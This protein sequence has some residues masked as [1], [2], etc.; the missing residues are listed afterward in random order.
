MTEPEATAPMHDGR[1]AR[2]LHRLSW[3]RVALTLR[4]RFSL[5][6]LVSV[7][8][9]VAAGTVA[10]S[11]EVSARLER[12]LQAQAM[13]VTGAIRTDLEQTA[14]ALDEELAV[15]ADPRAGVARLLTA[16]RVETRFLGAQARL[17][18]GRLEV[19][20]VL[21]KDGSILTSG[22]WPASFGALDPL[23]AAYASEPGRLPRIVDEA[24]PEGSSPALER[25]TT[26]RA[27]GRDLVVVAG[28]FLDGP[29]LE[30]LRARTG[31]DLLAL[32]TA[33]S[34]ESRAADVDCLTAQAPDIL[35]DR[36]VFSPQDGFFADRLRLDVIDV[37]GL[38]L[39]V[40]LDRS[41]IE[42]VRSGIIWRAIVVGILSIVFAVVLGALVARRIVRPIEDLAEAA[43][44]VAAGDLSARVADPHT[45]GE[46]QELVD[47]F[48][49][50][51]KDLEQ[52]QRRLLQAERVAAWQE[53]ARGLAHELKNPLTPILSAMDVIR[54]AR[55]LNRPD[56]DAILHEQASAVVE[57]VM[58]L[59]ELAD[60]F[61]RF[62]R[63]PEKRPEPLLLAELLDHALAL[64]ASGIPV[65]RDYAAMAPVLADRT[66]LLTVVTNLV[67]NAV[68][69]MT[70]D[71]ETR[72][73]RPP[74]LKVTT[75]I[76]ADMVVM[77]LDDAG[78]GIAAEIAARLFTPYFTTKGSR[79]TG[80][81]LALAHRIIVEHAGTIEAGAGVLGGARFTVK[82]PLSPTQT[83]TVA[84]D[85]RPAE[86]A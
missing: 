77:H 66:Q 17:I 71:A 67:K 51:A 83:D 25:W 52:G 50:M 22:H 13:R 72:A 6:L 53:I 35:G 32:C 75:A 24:T 73:Q 1:I 40:G 9:A 29:A 42:R 15:A 26:V 78:P 55:Q 62:A 68:E 80:L 10:H 86:P 84:V 38:V 74:Q 14:T 63:L 2:L 79:G 23:I 8:V 44:R 36:T 31:A 16:G 49:L 60:A 37:G 18:S 76:E 7:A 81:G 70:M 30:R 45:G 3:Q 12:D 43:G 19:L 59:K 57:E 58:R 5:A 39:Y 69:A 85:S 27:S 46:V 54:R 4:W 21:L 56:F 48:N 61:A 20:K 65:E 82:L 11:V 64:Y 34:D 41:G 28:R 33:V 47:A